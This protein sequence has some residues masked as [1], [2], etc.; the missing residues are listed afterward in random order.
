M[1]SKQ[2]SVPFCLNQYEVPTPPRSDLWVDQLRWVV[3]VMD[4]DDG[5]LG[6]VASLLAYAIR[7]RGLT[8]RQQPHADKILRRI[9]AMWSE[10]RLRAQHTE[11]EPVM[12]P[13]RDLA[14]VDPAGE[15]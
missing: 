6:F 15:A 13:S 1:T 9:H 4:H 8:Q 10:G 12:S 7:N 2:E 3:A 11:P 14:H 5:D